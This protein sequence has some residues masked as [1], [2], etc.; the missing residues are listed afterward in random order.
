MIPDHQA[1]RDP[2]LRLMALKRVDSLQNLMSTLD[3]AKHRY[4]SEHGLGVNNQ[5]FQ[6][7]HIN[8]EHIRSSHIHCS[9]AQ[10]NRST[11]RA[12]QHVS[13]SSLHFTTAVPQDPALAVE[14]AKMMDLTHM[15]SSSLIAA[16]LAPSAGSQQQANT[17]YISKAVPGLNNPVHAVSSVK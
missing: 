17:I 11:P 2:R 5:T 15:D 1:S 10:A 14:E 8:P 7:A 12:S 4:W 3:T 6:A 16:A 13:P 9:P